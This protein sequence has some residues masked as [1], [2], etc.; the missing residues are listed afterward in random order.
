MTII[1]ICGY[2]GSGKDTLAKILINEHNFIKFSFADAVKDI[3]TS[4][5]GWNRIILDGLTETDRI[6]REKIDTWWS[7]QLNISITP[8]YMMQYI[9]TELFRNHLHKDIWTK[10]VEKKII[11]FM[12]SN[13]NKNI[14]ITDCRY[15][16]EIEMVQ[17]Y[18]GYIFHIYRNLPD[19]YEDYKNTKELPKDLP[20]HTSEI[21]WL[22]TKFDYTIENNSTIENL[23]GIIFNIFNY[24]NISLR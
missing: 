8:R 20:L 2:Q 16:N 6:E 4:I 5:F 23:S 24:G 3:L 14:V 21:S 11:D 9:G 13:K 12:S 19:W 17:K 18:D 7:E 10:V 15:P 22:D 1:V